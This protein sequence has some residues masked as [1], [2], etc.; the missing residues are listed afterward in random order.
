MGTGKS[1]LHLDAAGVEALARNPNAAVSTPP[2]H[3]ATVTANLQG[4]HRHI[5]TVAAEL[6]RVPASLT[7]DPTAPFEP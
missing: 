2:E 3:V 7:A 1:F 5:M 6:S 4:L